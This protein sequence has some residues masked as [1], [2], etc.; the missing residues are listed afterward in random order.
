MTRKVPEFDLRNNWK[1][2]S[3]NSLFN[4]PFQIRFFKDVESPHDNQLY[5]LPI[6]EFKNIYDGLNLG[7]NVNNK[8]VLNKPFLFGITP[9]YSVTSNALTGGAKVRYNTFFEDQ[10]LYNINFGMAITHA[11]FAEDAFVTKTVPYVNF[12]FRDASNLRSN[13][14]KSL[15]FR[16]VGIEKDFVK[17]R[18]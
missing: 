5:F 8:G 14:L 17:S 16:Y 12:N 1:S 15:S 11:S 6:V 18:R 13:E 3:G 9:I 7:M 10:N 2:I 4:K